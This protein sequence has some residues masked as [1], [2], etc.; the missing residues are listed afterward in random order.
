MAFLCTDNFD[1]YANGANLGNNTAA[2]GTGWTSNW[3]VN[4]TGPATATNA[5][6]LSSPNSA[7][8]T[9]NQI[10]RLFSAVSVGVLNYSFYKTADDI[11][12]Y[13]RDGATN[14]VINRINAGNFEYYDGTSFNSLGAV[15]SSAWHTVSIEIDQT[16]QAGK[17]RYKID[18]GAFSSWFLRA[19]GGVST[20]CDRIL[21]WGTGNVYVD[22]ISPPSSSTGNSNF[23]AFM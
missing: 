19:D 11:V 21:L 23:L 3:G 12:F 9:L 17:V 4:L 5:Q 10:D 8:V 7:L 22:S 18:G 1:S 20:S 16:N 13:L 14:F 15:S 2:G 6:S